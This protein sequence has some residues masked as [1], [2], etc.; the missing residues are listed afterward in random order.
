MSAQRHVESP[1]DVGGIGPCIGEL[2]LRLV[3]ELLAAPME[4][5]LNAD[6]ERIEELLDFRL[7]ARGWCVEDVEKLWFGD[8]DLRLRSWQITEFV[9][10]LE[11][12]MVG[13]VLHQMVEDF[14]RAEADG[15]RLESM[16]SA[17]RFGV[18]LLQKLARLHVERRELRYDPA[19]SC[20]ADAVGTA[21]I[22]CLQ[23]L[24]RVPVF[25]DAMPQLWLCKSLDAR[26]SG[27]MAIYH[28][29]LPLLTLF[30]RLAQAAHGLSYV[31]VYAPTMLQ[32]CRAP[33]SPTQRL[34]Y[35]IGN[36]PENSPDCGRFFVKT[37]GNRKHCSHLCAQRSSEADPKPLVDTVDID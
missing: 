31:R 37:H 2:R 15:P 7:C 17:L 1:R 27:R 18:R 4:E 16:A 22:R 25:A 20:S 11:G 36:S 3:K 6:L 32:R 14:G 13:D 21:E 34:D 12:L 26:D 9:L 30:P 19:V 10:V 28:Q 33:I 5:I 29:A 24:L 23:A 35:E 8:V